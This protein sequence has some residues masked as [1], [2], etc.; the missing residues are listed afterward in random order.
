MIF[1]QQ[2]KICDVCRL[3]DYDTTEK[4][5]GYCSLCDAYICDADRNRWD[6]R[7]K[8]ALKRKMEAGYS[9]LHNYEDVA[10]GKTIKGEQTL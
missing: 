5:C 2:F 1:T 4:L 9:G 3:L 6:R 7:I 8:A 10:L